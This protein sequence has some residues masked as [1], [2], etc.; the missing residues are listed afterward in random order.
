MITINKATSSKQVKDKNILRIGSNSISGTMLVFRFRDKDTRQIIHYAPA[1]ELTGYG[2]DEDK[3]FE[4]LQFSINNFFDYLISL[5]PKKR[6]AELNEF[7]WKQNS[8]KNK[9]FSK[10][11]IDIN[12][13]LK[14]F[15][16]VADEVELLTLQA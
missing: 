5:S 1:L 12:G 6:D 16:A 10:I 3:S 9:E 2:N 13:E 15:N 8:L 4:M 7:G 11:Y 14:N